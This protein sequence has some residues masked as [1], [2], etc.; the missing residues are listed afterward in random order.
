MEEKTRSERYIV[1][2]DEYWRPIYYAYPEVAEYENI[3]EKWIEYDDQ[4]RI[5]TERKRYESWSDIIIRYEYNDDIV[6]IYEEKDCYNFIYKMDREGN[7]LYYQSDDCIEE[8]NK[9]GTM[10]YYKEWLVKEEY[11]TEKWYDD[12]G[13]LIHEKKLNPDPEMVEEYFY[14]TEYTEKVEDY[15]DK[16]NV[17]HIKKSNGYE[18]WME[19]NENNKLVHSK[20]IANYEKWWKYDEKGNIMYSRDSLGYKKYYKFHDNALVHY[21]ELDSSGGIYDEYLF[22]TNGEPIDC[23]GHRTDT[24][25]IYEIDKL[26]KINKE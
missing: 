24:T 7:L 13:N 22:D 14:D 4:G 10:I 12:Y 21:I 11:A 16:G 25:W 5:I 6:T 1:K 17:I 18:A 2:H 9:N 8:Y 26:L 3:L 15:D 19:Y 20:D 23:F